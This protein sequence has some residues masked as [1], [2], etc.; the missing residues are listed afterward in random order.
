MNPAVLGTWR[1]L[2]LDG[3]A[4][5]DPVTLTVGRSSGRPR[6]YDVVW[7]EDGATPDRYDAYASCCRAPR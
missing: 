2:P 1:C 7:Q 3:D 4:H 6:V 5:E